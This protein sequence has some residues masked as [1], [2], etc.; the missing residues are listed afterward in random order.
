MYDDSW[1]LV[2]SSSDV[3]WIFDLGRRFALWPH[4]RF[5]VQNAVSFWQLAYVVA[6]RAGLE[7]PGVPNGRPRARAALDDRGRASASS[8]TSAA[9]RDPRAVGAAAHG[10]R[11]VH[12]V[13]RRPLP[14]PS[15][16]RPRRARL[17]GAV[18]MPRSRAR[19]RAVAFGAMAR[20]RSPRASTRRTTT[21]VAGARRRG[22][23]R[24]AGAAAPPGSAVPRV[25][26]GRGP[27]VQSSSAWP[28]RSTRCAGQSAPAVGAHVQI[29]DI[30]GA[31][32]LSPTN[33]AGNFYITT[34]QW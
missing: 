10:R 19:L 1:G 5:H 12:V 28:G 33:D 6:L 18:L 34:S 17:R 32:F 3:R 24:R 16:R 7:P 25:P 27:C 29:E 15:H 20:L 2:A 4:V 26:R 22:A 30:T 11:D 9:R 8:G 23:R 21:Q 14:D 31:A 13:P